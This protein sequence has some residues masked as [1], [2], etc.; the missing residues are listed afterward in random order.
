MWLYFPILNWVI[1]HLI[2]TVSNSLLFVFCFIKAPT[3]QWSGSLYPLSTFQWGYF[4]TMHELAA[5]QETSDVVVCFA[6][7]SSSHVH[8]DWRNLQK[9]WMEKIRHEL[10]TQRMLLFMGLAITEKLNY[11][12]GWDDSRTGGQ[13]CLWFL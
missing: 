7:G 12:N 6:G 3:R 11:K 1:L 13:L 9:H 5:L 8:W 2:N 10:R 4:S